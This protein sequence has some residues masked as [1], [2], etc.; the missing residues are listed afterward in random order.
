MTEIE[1]YQKL[2][3]ELRRGVLI[4]AVLAELREEHYGYSLRKNL[5]AKGLEIDEGTL[6]PLVRRLEKQGLLTSE[7]REESNRKKRFYKVSEI[8]QLTLEKLTQDWHQVEET[9]NRILN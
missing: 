7:W 4:L 2:K 6:Y 5:L 9:L 8:G 3:L 1:H